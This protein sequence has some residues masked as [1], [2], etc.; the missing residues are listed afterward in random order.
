MASFTPLSLQT[1]RLLAE[2]DIHG[3]LSAAQQGLT[4]DP[5]NALLWQLLGV[6]AA[7]LR[8]GALAGQCWD[9]AEALM[10]DLPELFYHRGCLA[11]DEGRAEDA[12][13][14]FRAELAR[15]S[16]HVPSL[17]NLGAALEAAG[18]DEG[19]QA[20][21]R[22]GLSL[23]PQAH[24]LRFNLGKLLYRQGRL[25]EAREALQTCLAAQAEDVDTLQLL[26]QLERELG[27]A[28][29]AELLLQG[30][31]RLQPRHPGALNNLGLLRM[32]Q[33]RW[34]EAEDLLRAAQEAGAATAPGN[35]AIL[36]VNSGRAA[37]AESLLR[38]QIARYGATGERLHH[39]AL[40]LMELRRHEEAEALLRE[41]LRLEPGHA[42]LRQNLGYLLLARGA[43]AE[44]WHCHESRPVSP[45]LPT[46]SSPRWQGEALGE[47]TLLLLFEQGYGDAIQFSRYL[48]GLLLRHRGP[49]TALCPPPLQTLFAERWPDIDWLPMPARDAAL[50][51]HDRHVYSMSLPWLL[52]AGPE[53]GFAYLRPAQPRRLR[54]GDGRLRVG[55]VWR[56]NADHPFDHCRSLPDIG[57]LGPLT[58]NVD[59]E[60]RSLQYRPDADERRW[61]AAQEVMD[62]EALSGGFAESASRLE[63]LDLLISVDTAMAH[64]AGAL[65]LPCWLLLSAAHTDW[66]WGLSGEASV[67]YPGMRLFRQREAG[68]W[69]GVIDDMARELEA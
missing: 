1:A 7:R 26:G 35:L 69:S 47:A 32:A 15:D 49:V 48:D 58:A 60:W 56:G 46:P 8:Q 39:R 44:G 19:A 62:A 50:P 41:G 68:D 12:A 63:E 11:L 45:L 16:A 25:A 13:A 27:H 36:L 31:L 51:A 66:R 57:L 53:A 14:A 6:C 67:W 17:G 52:K 23:A 10:P 43:F 30:A 4:A 9:R 38:V 65:G 55:L 20:A 64:L 40:A 59:I 24:W 28:A 21:W 2:D 22:A 42:R 34:A 18:D 29:Q 5:D 37:Q 61:L 3:A 54:H 33:R